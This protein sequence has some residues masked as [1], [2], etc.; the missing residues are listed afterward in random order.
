MDTQLSLALWTPMP[1][2][3]NIPNLQ[4]LYCSTGWC[5]NNLMHIRAPIPLSILQSQRRHMFDLKA[6]SLPTSHG[7]RKT[8]ELRSTKGSLYTAYAADESPHA[9]LVPS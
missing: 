7:G 1:R 6:Y 4:H 2:Y 3:L 9:S 8:C 5:N